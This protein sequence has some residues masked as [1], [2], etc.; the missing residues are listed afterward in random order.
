MG[1]SV[2]IIEGAIFP[3]QIVSRYIYGHIEKKTYLRNW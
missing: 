1:E 3:R 2:L